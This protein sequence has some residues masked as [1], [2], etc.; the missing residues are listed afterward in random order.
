MRNTTTMRTTNT[1]DTH[2][3]K[4]LAF[5]SLKLKLYKYGEDGDCEVDVGDAGDR[6][7]CCCCCFVLGGSS[8]VIPNFLNSELNMLDY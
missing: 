2:N 3:N 4:I 6:C 1:T 7:C 8:A 5:S